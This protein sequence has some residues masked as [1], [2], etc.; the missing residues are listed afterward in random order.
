MENSEEADIFRS[1]ASPESQPGGQ[2]G[3]GDDGA[4]VTHLSI[5][6]VDT[7]VVTKDELTSIDTQYWQASALFSAAMLFAGVVLNTIATGDDAD[8]GLLLYLL[9][10]AALAFGGFGFWHH[11]TRQSLLNQIKDQTVPP[12][13]EPM[14]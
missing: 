11:Q 6:Q 4:F 14:T 8:S 3:V 13:E 12:V 1:E 7:F 9:G 5:R 2:G 10:A